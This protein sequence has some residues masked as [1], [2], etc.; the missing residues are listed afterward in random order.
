MSAPARA[1][2]CSYESVSGV[3]GNFSGTSRRR[4]TPDLALHLERTMGLEPTWL[5]KRSR[6]LPC[7]PVYPSDRLAEV[8][9]TRGSAAVLPTL[10]RVTVPDPFHPHV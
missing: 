8:I 3:S 4:L 10:A 6:D 1:T 2:S 5:G 7:V 9:R